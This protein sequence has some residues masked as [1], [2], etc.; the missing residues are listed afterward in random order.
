MTVPLPLRLA[1]V[2]ALLTAATLL[3][4]AVVSLSVAR[5]HLDRN[6]DAQ[7][8]GTAQSF[9][10]GPEARAHDAA[11]LDLEAHRWLAQHPLPAGQMAAISIAGGRTLTS[12]GG[13]DLFEVP[14]PRTLLDAT[15]VRWLTLQGS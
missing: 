10:I 4:V 5:S 7:L 11:R 2:F 15:S 8:R 3:V 9:R 13:A 12:V 6:L 14:A 1:G